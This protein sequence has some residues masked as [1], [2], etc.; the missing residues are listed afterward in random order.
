MLSLPETFAALRDTALAGSPLRQGPAGALVVSGFAAEDSV[1]LLRAW[2]AAHALSQLTG[3]WPLLC[4]TDV[5]EDLL[6]PSPLD[7]ERQAE[8]ADLDRAAREVDPPRSVGPRQ[9]D[10]STVCR[11]GVG[12]CD[13]HRVA[14]AWSAG[15]ESH[16]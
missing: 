12:R 2:Q 13:T 7:G 3:R 6:E 10:A 4:A 15:A 9:D 11:V 5:G 14:L 8:L 1:A 16:G